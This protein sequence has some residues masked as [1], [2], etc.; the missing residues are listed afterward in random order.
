MSDL[1]QAA[2]N[3]IMLGQPVGTRNPWY[4]GITGWHT[5]TGTIGTKN[6]GAGALCIAGNGA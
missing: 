5:M 1:F 6:T 4:T 2:H 3:T